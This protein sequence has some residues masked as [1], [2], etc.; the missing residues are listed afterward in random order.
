[1]KK[2]VAIKKFVEDIRVV[3][4]GEGY[5]ALKIIETA[6]E[7]GIPIYEDKKLADELYEVELYDDVPEVLVDH[8]VK[9]LDFLY[10]MKKN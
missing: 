2:A 8:V 6:K 9:V 4:K 1:M 7:E 10:N 3:G 5:I